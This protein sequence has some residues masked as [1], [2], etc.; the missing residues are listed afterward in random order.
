MHGYRTNHELIAKLDGLHASI[1]GLQ[2]EFFEFIVEADR[3]Q[4]E[5]DRAIAS[6]KALQKRTGKVTV[7][8]LLSAKHE[9]HKY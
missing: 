1:A 8:E 3:R 6:I 5:I 7:E 9:G 4:A 2:R